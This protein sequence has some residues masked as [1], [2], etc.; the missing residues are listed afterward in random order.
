MKRI[1]TPYF[2]I[3]LI[4]TGF[5]FFQCS[6]KQDESDTS[7][8]TADSLS[9]SRIDYIEQDLEKKDSK[10]PIAPMKK[11]AIT[12]DENE[13]LLE[14]IDGRMMG[15]AEGKEAVARGTSAEIKAYGALMI[16]D[17]TAMLT[18]LKSISSTLD[19]SIPKTLTKEKQEGLADLKA[20]KDDKFDKKFAKM[21]TIDHKRDVKLFAEA[22]EFENKKIRTFADSHLSLIEKHLEGSKQLK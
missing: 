1:H 5:I 9:V 6:P 21:M 10:K 13:F 11:E 16:K 22:K 7:A 17:Q 3:A 18:T 14:A 4:I 15:I 8:S 2:K 20:C 12:E 19:F